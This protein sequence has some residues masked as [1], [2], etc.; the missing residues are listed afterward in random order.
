MN[1]QAA[2]EPLRDIT[3]EGAKA[4]GNVTVVTALLPENISKGFRVASNGDVEKVKGGALVKGSIVLYDVR[5]PTGLVDL[6]QSLSPAQAL[7]W[8]IPTKADA[9]T[10]VTRDDYNL[11][12]D[13]TTLTTRTNDAFAFPSGA[14]WLML[15]HD[16]D[17]DTDLTPNALV[18]ALRGAVPALQDAQM[19]WAQS[20]SS[21]IYYGEVQYRGLLGQRLYI[22]LA[23][24]ADA[25]R[26]G[27]VIADRLWLAGHGRFDV[28]S[29]GQ[30]LQRTL[31][32]TSV[33][34]PSRL[35]FAG[36]AA[37]KPPMSQRKT[38]P[39]VV[40][41]AFAMLD[42][43]VSLQDLTTAEQA[44]LA[45]LRMRM[46]HAEDLQID[47]NSAQTSWKDE[48]AAALTL[49]NPDLGA[50]ALEEIIERAL[51]QLLLSD[52][53]IVKVRVDGHM[54]NVTVA[55]LL[56]DPARYHG[57][58]TMDPLE[59]DYDGG[60]LV[61]ILYLQQARPMLFSQAHGG[62]S[63]R[64]SKQRQRIELLEGHTAETVEQVLQHL[65][66]NDSMYDFGTSLV[67]VSQGNVIPM[68]EHLLAN[69]L[70][71]AYQFWMQK[72][73]KNARYAL[74]RDPPMPVLKQLLALGLGRGLKPLEGVV[75]APVV[76]LD[77]SLLSSVGY[78][79][80]TRLLVDPRGKAMPCVPTAPTLEQA[81][82][83]LD[84]LW[85]PFAD[86]PFVDSG[87]RGALLSALLSAVVRPVLPT[88]PAFAFDAPVQGSGKT[89][90][91][92]CVGALAT[93]EAP[94]VYAHTAGRDDEEIRKRLFSALRAGTK[95]LVWDNIL[96][97]FD[98]A[99]LAMLLTSAAMTDR[100]LGVS[101]TATLPNRML[102]ILTGNNLS[103]AGDLPRRVLLCRIDPESATPFDRAFYLKPLAHVLEHRM[104]MAAA[105]LTLI[106]ARFTHWR[107]LARGET[108]SFEDWDRIVRQTVCYVGETVAPADYGDPMELMLE[109]A[110]SDPELA[111]LAA[112]LSEL[113]NVFGGG[114][115]T[116]ADVVP[117]LHIT[118]LGDCFSAFGNV[119]L[120][121]VSI[122]RV[123]KYR[124][125]RIADGLRLKKAPRGNVQVWR[126]EH[127]NVV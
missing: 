109:A 38:R 10:V 66:D 21:N 70:G 22:L 71:H 117:H 68:N 78:D 31:V 121:A 119:S 4:R 32:D 99:A 67:T 8:G 48:R 16:A 1:I 84:V 61:G 69:H 116:S 118:R 81:K 35:D 56:A 107:S 28:S 85:T 43:K 104:E 97:T 94:T 64:L 30:L 26:A 83:A 80:E 14:G 125:G 100:V 25:P 120:T 23:D 52:V 89:L 77:G 127:V 46:S 15:D 112:L 122:G 45:K 37:C 19:V 57:L 39:H 55:D 79:A 88:C 6:L 126:V 113:Q 72:T 41:G 111:D 47:V 95:A 105:A 42:S 106:R 36:G 13:K 58:Q 108:A 9:D 20:A 92:N 93:G 34:Q 11:A 33:W 63:F 87:A 18:E 53:F 96:G 86:F 2:P 75:T 65:R 40:P 27:A 17:G 101:E 102:F 59:P 98:S 90:L 5:S 76:R 123:L 62:K 3:A 73:S 110:A 12:S 49:S 115:F 51:G 103:L 114:S 7:I 60:R 82:A 24:A 29:S 124:V 91:A 50:E 74:D 54:Q 44:E